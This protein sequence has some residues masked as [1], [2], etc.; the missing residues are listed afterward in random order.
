MQFCFFLFWPSE[1]WW[2]AAAMGEKGTA[3]GAT[4]MPWLPASYPAEVRRTVGLWRIGELRD[5]LGSLPRPGEGVAT[6]W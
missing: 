3:A 1:C 6:P 5:R 4:A 2:A